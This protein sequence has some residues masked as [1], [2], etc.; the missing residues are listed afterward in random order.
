MSL[1][2]ER[3]RAQGLFYEKV[4]GEN[5]APLWRHPEM[6]MMKEPRPRALPHLWRYDTIRSTMM[7][8][9]R[10]VSATEA[11]RRVLLLVNPG[12]G[13]VKAPVGTLAGGVQMVMPGEVAPAHRHTPTA[14]RFVLESKGGAFTA[15]DGERARMEEGDFIV[16]PSGLWHDHSNDGDQPIL[17]LDGVDV[18]MARF[19]D[20]VFA[21]NYPKAHHPLHRDE[22]DALARYGNGLLPADWK[23]KGLHSPLFRYPYERARAALARLAKSD[24]PDPHNGHKLAYVNPATGDHAVPTMAAFLTLLP[25]GFRGSPYRSTESAV[26]VVAE[27]RGRSVIGETVIEWG[28]RDIFVVPNWTFARHEPESEAVL[29][30][31]SD[32]A[33]QQKLGFFREE[34]GA[35]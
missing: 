33:A 17:W 5:L 4:A 26:Y 10:V 31:Y 16:T 8:A 35:I 20:A 13:G 29:F 22:G 12:L 25:Q 1:T 34:R 30:N 23:P 24:T 11:E 21:D 2:E 6:N 19:F 3:A 9:G 32:R 7:E 18:P 27:G 15:V 28:P 14:I